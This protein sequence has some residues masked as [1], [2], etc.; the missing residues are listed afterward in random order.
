M[1]SGKRQ[2]TGCTQNAHSCRQTALSRTEPLLR[3]AGPRGGGLGAHRTRGVAMPPGGRGAGEDGAEPSPAAPDYSSQR[4]R[5]GAALQ[6]GHQL[7]LPLGCVRCALVMPWK[8]ILALASHSPSHPLL[9]SGHVCQSLCLPFLDLV[10][11]LCCF[12]KDQ[13]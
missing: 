13:Q 3:E 10:L 11:N 7:F 6:P 9:S 4:A 1:Y 12:V 5:A 8:P 2:P